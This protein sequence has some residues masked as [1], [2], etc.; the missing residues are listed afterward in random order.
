MTT[1]SHALRG[2]RVCHPMILASPR[3]LWY[4][5]LELQD[6]RTAALFH[7]S[8]MEFQVNMT[9]FAGNVP[10]PPL[11][12]QVETVLLLREILQLQREQVACL[13]NLVM[14]HDMT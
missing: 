14:A 8:Y 11:S 10:Q 2:L 6:D 13:R 9:P 3:R 5:N 4:K 12:P 7:G 1:P